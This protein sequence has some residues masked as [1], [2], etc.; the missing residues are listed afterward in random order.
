MLGQSNNMNAEINS[1][2]SF[3]TVIHKGYVITEAGSKTTFNAAS[4]E[5]EGSRSKAKEYKDL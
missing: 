5:D 3:I 1:K 4:Y 2:R